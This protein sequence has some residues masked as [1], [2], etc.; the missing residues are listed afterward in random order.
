VFPEA[1]DVAGYPSD[2]V[3]AIYLLADAPEHIPL[4][5]KLIIVKDLRTAT[6]CQQKQTLK[7]QNA[8]MCGVLRDALASN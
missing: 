8:A 3:R 5:Y 6:N 7:M 4:L 2:R 1:K